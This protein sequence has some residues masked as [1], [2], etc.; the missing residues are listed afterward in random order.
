MRRTIPPCHSI[1]RDKQGT[2]SRQK[3]LDKSAKEEEKEGLLESLAWHSRNL[4]FSLTYTPRLFIRSG[5]MARLKVQ[6][7]GFSGDLR[8]DYSGSNRGIRRIS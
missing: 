2:Q 6:P 3:H 7:L 8:W 5:H 4:R 1:S